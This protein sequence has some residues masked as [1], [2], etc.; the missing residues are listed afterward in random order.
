MNQQHGS[1]TVTVTGPA[2]TIDLSLGLQNVIT[3][4]DQG[5]HRGTFET[6]DCKITFEVTHSSRPAV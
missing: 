5:S 3:L 1:L 2:N 6:S 4:L